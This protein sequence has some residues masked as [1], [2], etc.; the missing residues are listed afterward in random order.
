MIHAI[1][2]YLYDYNCSVRTL[3]LALPAS[4][5]TPLGSGLPLVRLRGL[6]PPAAHT[7]LSP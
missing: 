4:K 3:A 1:S 5:H 2:N 7:S 6:D